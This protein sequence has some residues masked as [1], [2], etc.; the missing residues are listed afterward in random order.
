MSSIMEQ[1][2]PE[3]PALFAFE[4]VKIAETD[5]VYTLVST[6]IN[7]STPKLMKM[8]HKISDEFDYGCNRTRTV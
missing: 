6:N 7:Q 4:F 8:H 3:H 2:K 5:L 1:I